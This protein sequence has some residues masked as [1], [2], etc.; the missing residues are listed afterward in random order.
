MGDYKVDMI[1][2]GMQEFYVQ[3]HGPKDSTFH[4][5]LFLLLFCFSDIYERKS[6]YFSVDLIVKLYGYSSEHKVD[7]KKMLSLWVYHVTFGSVIP[8]C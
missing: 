5:H 7:E 6:P 3:F 4:I 2:D 1:N 8:L